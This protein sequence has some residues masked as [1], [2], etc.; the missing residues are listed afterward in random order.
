MQVWALIAESMRETVEK[1]I[2]WVNLLLS[3]A[4]IAAL[5]SIS[6]NDRG[7]EL[8]FGWRTFELTEFSTSN[9]FFRSLISLVLSGVFV[10]YYVG[11]LACILGLISTAGIFPTMI[12]KGNIDSILARPLSRWKIFFAKYVGGL[13]FMLVQA[14]F[15]IV[16]LFVVVGVRWKVWFPGLLW[17]IPLLVLLFSY[18]YCVCV[19]FGLWTRSGM[20]SLFLT[21]V[22]WSIPFTGVQ[23]GYEM[24]HSMLWMKD[25]PKIK[26]AT[27]ILQ[28]VVP[29]TTGIVRIVQGAMDDTD[30][31]EMAKFEFNQGVFLSKAEL[32]YMLEFERKMLAR[33]W[34]YWV[35]PSLLFEGVVL[36]VTGWRFSRKDF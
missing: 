14:T 32:D 31:A 22:V 11:W 7:V 20:A 19:A 36:L 12:Q 5:A 18:L 33:P 27:E 16:L 34:Y 8:L 15:F 17:S 3:S 2:F 10:D 25:F 23:V 9:P 1:K 6:F 24:S 29:S 21:L 13:F 4:V 35:G 28:W 26:Q 30:P